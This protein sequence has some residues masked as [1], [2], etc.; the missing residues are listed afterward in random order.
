MKKNQFDSYHLP[1][2]VVLRHHAISF[3]RLVFPSPHPLS[4]TSP[5]GKSFTPLRTTVV[6]FRLPCSTFFLTLRGFRALR[7][8]LRNKCAPTRIFKKAVVPP[9]T[10]LVTP[11]PLTSTPDSSYRHCHRSNTTV[12]R[13]SRAFSSSSFSTASLP[14]PFPTSP[15]V[16]H[17]SAG[18][19]LPPKITSLFFSLLSFRLYI[20]SVIHLLFPLFFP[21][22]WLTS[23]NGCQNTLATLFAAR[24]FLHHSLFLP[25]TSHEWR[26]PSSRYV[27]RARGRRVARRP[28]E[29]SEN[30]TKTRSSINANPR[31]QFENFYECFVV[32]IMSKE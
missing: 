12:P 3:P 21:R 15:G 1:S 7:L 19:Q 24:H 8:A 29:D 17:P 28:C 10:V 6:S 30:D 22:R 13:H 16:P 31:Y 9:T 5:R 14:P 32:G 11:R 25:S 23:P 18:P 4:P 2:T 20:V 27:P 26:W